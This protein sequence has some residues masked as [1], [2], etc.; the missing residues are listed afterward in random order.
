MH[1]VH[2]PSHETLMNKGDRGT[3]LFIVL[4]GLL[5]VTLDEQLHGEFK[6]RVGDSFGELSLL[7]DAP[8]ASTITATNQCRLFVLPRYE[9]RIVIRTTYTDTLA[10]YTKLVME[11]PCLA[12]LVEQN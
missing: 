2:L 3:A 12:R 4:E 7:Y 9:F 11:V 6:I 8:R 5:S 1:V 10:A